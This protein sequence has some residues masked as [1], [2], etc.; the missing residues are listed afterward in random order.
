MTEK[1]ENHKTLIVRIPEARVHPNADTLELIDILG[2]QLVAKKGNYAPGDL[3]VYI[4]PDS[5]VPQIPAFAWLWEGIEGEVPARKRRITV[6]KFRK[7]YS[8]GLLMPLRELPQLYIDLGDNRMTTPEEG[9]DVSDILGITHWEGDTEGDTYGEAAK[10][11]RVKRRPKTVMGWLRYFYYNTV[12]VLTGGRAYRRESSMEVK[13]DAPEYDVVSAKAARSGFAN[14]EYVTITEK[15]HGSNGRYLFLDG[16]FYIGSHF[17]WK[18]PDTPCIFTRVVEQRPWIR[19]WCEANP[20]RIL[21]GEVIGDQK[22][23]TYGLKPG[24]LDFRAFDIWEPAGYWTK[25][26]APGNELS[27]IENVPIL[28][29]GLADI[30]KIKELTDG[31]S[32]IDGKTQREGVVVSEMNKAPEGVRRPRQ[33]KRVSNVFLEKDGQ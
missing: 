32:S 17:Q 9:T 15:L 4:Q 3:A 24:E 14:T 26:W 11:P 7:E 22:G 8:E 13:F 19:K 30:E 23:Y 2:Y 18:A 29:V 33:V 12:R 25:P 6:R 27:E 16:V 28:Y 10:A 21:Y 31:K 5:V 1:P 20:G